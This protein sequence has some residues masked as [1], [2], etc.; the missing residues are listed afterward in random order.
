MN[1]LVVGATGQ[2][3]GMV[4]EQLQKA[5]QHKVAAMARKK[6]QVEDFESKGITAKMADLEGSVADLQAAMKDIDAVVFT[7]GSGGSTGY[8]KTLLIDLDGAVKTAEAAQKAGI[9]SFIMVS[10]IA[11]NDR[12]KWSDEMKP[13]MAAKY[14]ADQM[15]EES[16]LDYTIFRPGMLENEPGTGKIQL[17]KET[18]IK[19]IPREDVASTIVAALDQSNI[20]RQSFDLIS[21]ETPI[22]EAL[23]QIN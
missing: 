17:G 11:S 3:G 15:I 22:K 14:Y 18:A 8:D 10:S 20:S 13:Y 23:N 1:V 2:I 12:E 16:D 4:V 21:G 7:A 19:S 6:E 9:K 5:E